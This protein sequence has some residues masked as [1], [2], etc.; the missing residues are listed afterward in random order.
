MTSGV[1]QQVAPSSQD[2]SS[3]GQAA[4]QSHSL[5]QLFRWWEVLEQHEV[6]TDLAQPHPRNKLE[7]CLVMP[8][9][10]IM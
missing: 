4:R 9:F 2:R 10:K 3:L 6:V 8:F 5:V 1:A 7:Y